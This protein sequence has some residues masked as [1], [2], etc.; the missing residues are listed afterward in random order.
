MTIVTGFV[1]SVRPSFD[2]V[3]MAL[4]SAGAMQRWI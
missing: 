3:R 2:K 1:D 4:L